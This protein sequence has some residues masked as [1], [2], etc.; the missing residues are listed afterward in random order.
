MGNRLDIPVRTKGPMNQVTQFD[1]SKHAERLD[2]L[3]AEVVSS[4]DTED[5]QI[6]SEKDLVAG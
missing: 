5:D 4:L 3:Q 2:R 6:L 1:V